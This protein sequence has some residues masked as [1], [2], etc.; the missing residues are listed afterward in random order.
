M[1]FSDYKYAITCWPGLKY[2][3]TFKVKKLMGRGEKTKPETEF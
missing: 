1:V 2:V 3:L